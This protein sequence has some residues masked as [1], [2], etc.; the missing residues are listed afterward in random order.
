MTG[1]QSELGSDPVGARK[2]SAEAVGASA[3]VEASAVLRDEMLA[4]R[5]DELSGWL[6][7]AAQGIRDVDFDVISSDAVNDSYLRQGE[8]GPVPWD[9]TVSM[10]GDPSCSDA[11]LLAAARE[12]RA[13]EGASGSLT[14]IE[15][16]DCSEPGWAAGC[17]V[18]SV[19]GSS[20]CLT[21]F[22]LEA[23]GWRALDVARDAC[24]DELVAADAPEP[25]ASSVAENCVSAGGGGGGSSGGDPQAVVDDF[26]AAW[27]AGDAARIVRMPVIPELAAKLPSPSGFAWMTFCDPDRSCTVQLGEDYPD[28]FVSLEYYE[29][30][31]EADGSGW[32][33]VSLVRTGP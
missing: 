25:W 26:V 15:S 24:P 17:P 28:R 6:Q 7:L 3:G 20:D 13:A 8:P 21:F 2:V 11:P 12:A 27:V 4:D 14:S 32:R 1:I 29:V 22:R 23:D 16:L 9:V 33:I 18:D 5:V 30:G 10:R 31:L 19:T